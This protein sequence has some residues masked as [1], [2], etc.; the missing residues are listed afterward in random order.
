MCTQ[1]CSFLW[2]A[3]NPDITWSY[4]PWY[5]IL[6]APVTCP[7]LSL[8]LSNTTSVTQSWGVFS[9][10]EGMAG[11]PNN[12]SLIDNQAVC[13]RNFLM[14]I[15]IRLK[16]LVIVLEHVSIHGAHSALGLFKIQFLSKTI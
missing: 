9:N 6:I 1:R 13:L 10:K 4:V 16:T 2:F 5:S 15:Y 3:R 7:D 11:V 8:A 14:H 12:I